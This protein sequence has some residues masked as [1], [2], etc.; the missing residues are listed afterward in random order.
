MKGPR[1]EAELDELDREGLEVRV[2]PVGVGNQ[3]PGATLVLIDRAARNDGIAV[4][5][6][7]PIG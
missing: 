7:V 2:E 4:R 5:G 6:D 3:S 1:P